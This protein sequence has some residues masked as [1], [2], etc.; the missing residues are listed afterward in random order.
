MDEQKI[1]WDLY[2][3]NMIS[4]LSF[5]PTCQWIPRNLEVDITEYKHSFKWIAKFAEWDG[6]L[7]S[8]IQWRGSS[9]KYSCLLVS[10]RG[11]IPWDT[12]IHRRWSHLCEM[13]KEYSW[14][15]AST[16][17]TFTDPRAVR[18]LETFG[19]GGPTIVYFFW[20]C[21]C[22]CSLLIFMA[23]WLVLTALWEQE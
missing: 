15:S 8:V 3:A 14:P 20:N 10:V 13:V 12:K 2:H 6:D 4:S 17:F 7:I 9:K 16:D 18:I 1:H 5:H 23:L 19:S 21:W 11:W 22:P